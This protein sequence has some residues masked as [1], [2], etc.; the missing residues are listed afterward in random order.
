[1]VR[2]P[3]SA[4]MKHG[5]IATAQSPITAFLVVKIMTQIWNKSAGTRQRLHPT[6]TGSPLSYKKHL[7]EC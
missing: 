1:M 7:K 2:Q 3:Q 4:Q 5:T 6:Q